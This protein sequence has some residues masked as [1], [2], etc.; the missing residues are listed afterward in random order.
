MMTPIESLPVAPADELPIRAAGW[1]LLIEPAPIPK[2]S[3]GGIDLPEETVAA[4]QYLRNVGQ[5]MGMGPLAFQNDD[6]FMDTDDA[7]NKRPVHSCK[8]GD[9]VVF[10]KHSGQPV[11]VDVAGET[12][13]FKLFNDDEVLAVVDDPACLITKL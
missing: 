5:V 4:L 7:G 8:V 12:R 11:M 3:A 9:W 2:T 6:R 13:T 10:A 1:R